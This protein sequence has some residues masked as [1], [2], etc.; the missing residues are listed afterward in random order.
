VTEIAAGTLARVSPN[1]NIERIAHLGGGPNGA[2]VGPDGAVY[3]C[4]NGGSFPF[5]R[6]DGLL[7]FGLVVTPSDSGGSMD[8]VD[9]S[10]GGATTLSRA[11]SAR[12]LRG[13]N[14]L[15]LAG[16][17]PGIVQG[18]LESRIELYR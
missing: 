5:H 12:P 4:N 9:L 14:D 17:A 1:G 2:A 8:R 6:Q 3:V 13:P 18:G 7:V 11:C 10:T 16:I 15:D